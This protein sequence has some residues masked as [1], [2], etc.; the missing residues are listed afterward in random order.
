MTDASRT[1]PED[2]DHARCLREAVLAAERLCAEQGARLTPL[3]RRVLELIWG[4]HSPVGAYD[5][6]ER[7]K[8]ERHRAAPPTVYRALDF[9][10]AQGLIHKIESRNAYVG[11]SAPFRRHSGQF[12]ICSRCGTATEIADPGIERAIS[13]S[14]ERLG[15]QVDRPVVEVF[16]LCA[17]CGRA[18]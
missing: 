8:Q 6:L 2:H 11:C 13:G 12:L 10:R 17:A 14:A 16:G 9:L 4:D 5:L 7:L 18:A 15:F 1:P 3:R